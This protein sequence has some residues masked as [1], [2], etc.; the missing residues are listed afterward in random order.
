MK[1]GWLGLSLGAAILLAPTAR[2][3][4]LADGSTAF[5]QPP[6]FLDAYTS[7]PSVMRRNATY[8]FTLELPDNAD[9]SLQAVTIAPQNL[10]RHLQPYRLDRTTAFAKTPDA[11]TELGI[12]D[13]TVDEE[14]KT[15]TVEFDPPVAPG[16]EVTIALRP[17]RNPRFGGVYVFRVTAIP[18]GEQ[19]RTHIAGHGRLY[20]DDN[21]R[22][23][24]F[25]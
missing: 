20:F 17:Q 3:I 7:N 12:G 14:T 22:D 5:I 24:I 6:Q 16:R 2:A 23:R 10:T 1:F 11:E 4:E 25:D 15:V 13:V 21:D 9:A 8:F 18:E 19:P